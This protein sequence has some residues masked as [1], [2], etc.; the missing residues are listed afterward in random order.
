MPTV[1]LRTPA[2]SFGVPARSSTRRDLTASSRCACGAQLLSTRARLGKPPIDDGF[3][4]ATSLNGP[5]IR[6]ARSQI[7]QKPI[8]E[9]LDATP[10][11]RLTPFSLRERLSRYS[12]A[13]FQRIP[14]STIASIPAI[15]RAASTAASISSSSKTTVSLGARQLSSASYQLQ[16]PVYAT[17]ERPMEYEGPPLRR[18]PTPEKR[19]HLRTGT[20]P[21]KGKGRVAEDLETQKEIAE[22][23][24]Q[25]T[26]LESD[27]A[28][29]P[30]MH[31]QAI[32]Q[33]VRS[34]R[35]F[36]RELS[37]L[38]HEKLTARRLA[39][40]R[41]IY[42]NLPSDFHGLTF[43][44]AKARQKAN[45]VLH[46]LVAL[47]LPYSLSDKIENLL[48]RF[49]ANI[50]IEDAFI[51]PFNM[52]LKSYAQQINVEGAL[53]T[54]E[55][56]KELGKSVPSVLPD[57][58]TYQ[59]II[60]MYA[61]RREP[62]A[63][64]AAFEEMLATG[65]EPSQESYTSLMNAHVEAGQWEQAVAIFEHLDS[66]PDDHPLKPD[67]STC[68]TLIKCY[69]L[70]G[71]STSDVLS[72][73]AGMV[74]RKIRPTPRTF[75][76]LLQSACDGGMMDF[77]EEI[78]AS[79]DSMPAE[80]AF[81]RKSDRE[82]GGLAN[83][84]TFTVMIR[85]FI[86][87]GRPE[88]AK[89][90]YEEM[91]NRGIEPS[92]ATW[93]T[94]I[95]AFADARVNDPKAE[96]IIQNLLSE[97]LRTYVEELDPLQGDQGKPAN[98]EQ[99]LKL[100]RYKKDK[101]VARST[102]LHSVYGPVIS[103]YGKI[104][105]AME[106]GGIMDVSQAGQESFDDAQ[107]AALRVL[108]KFREMHDLP[109]AKPSIHIYTTLLDA[110]RRANDIEQVRAIWG[111]LFNL[112]LS[113][114]QDAL[115]IRA[116]QEAQS[117]NFGQNASLLSPSQRNILC[118]PLSVY[119]EALS[120]NHLHSE[121][122]EVWVQVQEAG[123]GFDAGN[124]NHLVVALLRAGELDRAFWT[125]EKILLE[126]QPQVLQD[127]LL[128]AASQAVAAE[129]SVEANNL[130]EAES[131]HAAETSEGEAQ[132]RLAKVE[133]PL[134][135]PNRAHELRVEDKK[136]RQAADTVLR[137]PGE[138]DP[139]I[140]KPRPAPDS[141]KLT[142]VEDHPEDLDSQQSAEPAGTSRPIS[143]GMTEN[144]SSA[145]TGSLTS[146]FPS[147]R[148]RRRKYVWTAYSATLRTMEDSI[149]R[150]RR[151][152]GR[153]TEE[154]FGTGTEKQRLVAEEQLQRLQESY[155]RSW[156]AIEEFRRKTN[157]IAAKYRS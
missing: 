118:L 56:M 155:P 17:V 149:V 78:F 93:S 100:R 54:L 87:A 40:A 19:S 38:P 142:P 65:L 140:E 150:L 6:P 132:A 115:P 58:R 36:V 120:S 101:A 12:L 9:T 49:E 133:P 10:R 48:S 13:G 33:E 11:P 95:G 103:A 124:W 25:L 34:L 75:V 41:A 26:S 109:G 141:Q 63:A 7:K 27:Q 89:Q 51:G 86:R 47:H 28:V 2:K 70:M 130:H 134:R 3:H 108:D 55:R 69:T 22:A 37:Y 123:F 107:H 20:S 96:R 4:I 21:N 23:D 39:K 139:S 110:Y 50:C 60:T 59:H 146:A 57:E 137:L 14:R 154:D 77:A 144:T 91:I 45:Y 156:E 71:A 88:D 128:P 80:K 76:L 102:A 131:E 24:S 112:A 5:S 64:R 90:Y 147:I 104:A 143:T 148:A 127:D 83:Q 16:Q 1:K 74:R 157:R 113:S 66:H 151:L 129:P 99:R 122:A 84:Y 67:A 46:E 43:R 125:V 15:A 82:E 117:Q 35:K 62:E 111:S 152:A 68:T 73:Y 94:L 53:Q 81:E 106:E 8:Y 105:G 153:T 72:V 121:V 116:S 97:F 114:T 79:M 31:R 29:S 32:L 136:E 92:S 61:H 126:A 42:Y 30:S 135:P 18:K 119:I 98:A 145:G 52:L 138:D 44:D 85:G